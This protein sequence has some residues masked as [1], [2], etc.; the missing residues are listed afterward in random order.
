MA[1]CAILLLLLVGCALLTGLDRPFVHPLCIGVFVLN[2]LFVVL[3]LVLAFAERRKLEQYAAMTDIPH[4][5]EL[6]AAQRDKVWVCRASMI[7]DYLFVAHLRLGDRAAAKAMIDS[8]AIDTKN[9]LLSYPLFCLYITSGDRATA[10]VYYQKLMACK[11]K[12]L[13][14][15]KQMAQK[16]CQ[17]A[18]TQIFDQEVYTTTQY[19][20]VKDW[21]SHYN[22]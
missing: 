10:D 8:G 7:D 3:L 15:Q 11:L 21:C 22:R 18:D 19:Q 6:L 14:Q 5:I 9:N 2:A 1:I 12:A 13:A 20:I 16:M 4:A 17:M